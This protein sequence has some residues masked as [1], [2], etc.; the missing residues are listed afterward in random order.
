M[1]L[2][3]SRRQFLQLSAAVAAGACGPLSFGN[4]IRREAHDACAVGL[5]AAQTHVPDLTR[6]VVAAG[7]RVAAVGGTFDELAD[8]AIDALA[9]GSGLA[10]PEDAARKALER[11]LHVFAADPLGRSVTEWRTLTE[12]ARHRGVVLRTD[13]LSPDAPSVRQIASLIDDAELGALR[14]IV[15]WTSRSASDDSERDFRSRGGRVLNVPLLVL[16]SRQPRSVYGAGSATAAEFPQSMAVRYEFPGT[17]EE[18]PFFVTWYDGEWAPP[19]ESIDDYPLPSSGALYLGETGQLLDDP[20]TGARVLFRNGAP[21]Q[22]LPSLASAPHSALPRWLAA[23]A[24][25]SPNSLKL[26]PAERANAA[27]L[28]G[29]ASYRAQHSLEWD[30]LALCARNCPEADALIDVP[31]RA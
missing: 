7:A 12:L 30:A 9:I 10:A 17:S 18:T 13:S 19:Y 3:Q 2:S 6:A 23:C 8:V 21:S 29:L 20:V 11:G 31:R 24:D 27:V 16:G 22:A 28:A 15:C 26:D 5:L 4:P 25:L 14:E 1:P